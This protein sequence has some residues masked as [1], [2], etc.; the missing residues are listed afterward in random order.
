MMMQTQIN[1]IW[2]VNPSWLKGESFLDANVDEK[3]IRIAERWVQDKIIS[4]ILG[5]CF[6]NKLYTYVCSGTTEP[7]LDNLLQTYILPVFVWAVPMELGIPLTFKDRNAGRVV[8]N[9][10]QYSASPLTEIKEVN[11]YY[12]D[13]VDFYVK[14]LAEFILCYHKE[15]APECQFPCLRYEEAT[16]NFF[17]FTKGDSIQKLARERYATIFPV[18]F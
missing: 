14:E 4:K 9:D 17:G 8:L 2:L 10:D 12:K 16:G 6:A 18:Q 13:K 7:L 3:S 5:G 1:K 11:A 15:L